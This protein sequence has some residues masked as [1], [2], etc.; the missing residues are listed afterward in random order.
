MPTIEI[1]EGKGDLSFDLAQ[2]LAVIEPSTSTLEWYAVE[3]EPTFL[4]GPDGT[5]EQSPPQWVLDLW[6]RIENC[7]N[8][9]KVSWQ[10]LKEFAKHAGQ[11]INALFI[12]IRPGHPP[13][14]EPL[15]LNSSTYEIVVQAFDATM[16]AI[17]SQNEAL[18]DTLRKHFKDT[19]IVA[20]TSR[21]Y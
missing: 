6:H 20:Q 10:E 14:V 11:T 5:K 9:I 3:F 4:V 16:W 19:K 7:K 18:L 15:D 12:A 21:Y 1:F 2:V 17:T 13:P 8:G